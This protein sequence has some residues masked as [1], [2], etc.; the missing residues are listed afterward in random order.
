M[1]TTKLTTMARR[2]EIFKVTK[3]DPMSWGQRGM[4]LGAELTGVTG[5][6]QLF[7]RRA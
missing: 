3:G 6:A 1:K 7:P 2:K 5:E 4:A